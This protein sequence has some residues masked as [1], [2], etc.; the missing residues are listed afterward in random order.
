MRMGNALKH[1][2]DEV[3][4]W[5]VVAKQYSEAYE[6]ARKAIKTN[7]PVLLPLEF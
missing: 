3:V 5:D 2:L 6:L 4:S 1:Y 7:K